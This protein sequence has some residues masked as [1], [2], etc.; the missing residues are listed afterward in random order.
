MRVAIMQPTYLPWSGYFGLIESVDLF[1]FLDNVQFD[2]RGWQQRNQIKTANGPQWLTIPV[3]SKGV[4]NQKINQVKIDSSSKFSDKHIKSISHNY[5]NAPFYNLIEKELFNTIHN[6]SDSL[7]ETNIEIIHTLSKLLGVSTPTISSSALNCSGIK[8]DMLVSI[9]QEVGASEY[10]SPPGSRVYLEKS[11]AFKM[12]KIPVKYFQ[13]EHPNYQQL[14]G[15]FVENMSVV[16]ILM[17]CGN[18][19]LDF[20]KNGSLL[21]DE[22]SFTNNV[23]DS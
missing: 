12:A 3:L 1:V 20:I 5:N 19:S 2:K 7:S 11:D 18:Q 23:K 16:D 21:L 8:A 13:F 10:L 9:C 17:N 4:R 22:E 14:F 15:D 6:S